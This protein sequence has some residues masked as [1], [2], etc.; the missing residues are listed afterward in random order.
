MQFIKVKIKEDM[1]FI[2]FVGLIFPL[3][4][5]FSGLHTIDEGYIGVYYRGGAI[6]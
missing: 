5:I 3:L 1:V 4:I 2:I 6:L